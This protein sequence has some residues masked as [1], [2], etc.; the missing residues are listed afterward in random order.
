MKHILTSKYWLLLFVIVL[1]GWSQP[2]HADQP[3]GLIQTLCIPEP[4]VDY[5]SARLES[6]AEAARYINDGGNGAPKD[7]G[8]R[9]KVLEKYGLIFP[10][11]FTYTCKLEHHTYTIT[12]R[13]PPESNSECMGDP[14]VEL[15]LKRDGETVLDNVFFE[16]SCDADQPNAR[17]GYVESFAVEDHR[18]YI[19]V[20]LS[21]GKL[22]RDM[23]FES[24][25]GRSLKQ[26]QLNCLVEHGYLQPKNWGGA[27]TVCMNSTGK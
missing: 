18:E 8:D 14:R 3:I 17:Y 2:A 15:S 10:R 1:S 7:K 23:R 12:G 27:R 5:F 24:G 11:E 13:R 20:V 6:F 16:P 4:G 26:E 25:G 19:E 21:D 9:L 22:Q